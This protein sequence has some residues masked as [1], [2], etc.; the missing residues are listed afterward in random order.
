MGQLRC[1]C[2]RTSRRFCK[3]CGER[4]SSSLRCTTNRPSLR[5]ICT[6]AGASKSR[7]CIRDSG[8]IVRKLGPT[9]RSDNCTRWVACSG[10]VLRCNPANILARDSSYPT[11]QAGIV[12]SL[13]ASKCSGRTCRRVACTASCTVRHS[14]LFRTT[15]CTSMRAPRSRSCATRTS[16]RT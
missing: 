5:G 14:S 12:W 4:K 6:H 2:S 8:R 9:S 15:L 7:A 11:S 1:R 13:A 3:A 16:S 10:P